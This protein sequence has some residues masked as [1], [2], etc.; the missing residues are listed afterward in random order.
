MNLE[1]K[2]YQAYMG[3]SFVNEFI[4]VFKKEILLLSPRYYHDDHDVLSGHESILL[5]T[6]DEDAEVQVYETNKPRVEPARISIC[7]LPSPP[8][9]I[10]PMAEGG[11]KVSRWI[12][13]SGPCFF[14][15][16]KGAQELSKTLY[17]CLSQ[18]WKNQVKA[19]ESY[20]VEFTSADI[21]DDNIEDGPYSSENDFDD[22]D[23]NP[24]DLL[25]PETIG[26]AQRLGWNPYAPQPS[27]GQ[28]EQPSSSLVKS[29]KS[30][31]IHPFLEHGVYF[32][33][34]PMAMSMYHGGDQFSSALCVDTE[35]KSVT[36][37]F[38]SYFR[39]TKK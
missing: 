6:Q 11:E 26:D 18:Y 9:N 35:V 25:D 37:D 10:G 30:P 23:S 1:R 7:D 8:L 4:S 13:I 34:N 15:D 12:V 31:F 19:G 16:E 29:R 28:Y 24:D 22:Q 14:L 20:F 32:G 36:L 17:K 33:T 5:R 2:L 27:Q 39:T 3:D 21:G 38:L